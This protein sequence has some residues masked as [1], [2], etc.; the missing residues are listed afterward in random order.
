VLEQWRGQRNLAGRFDPQ[1]GLPAQFDDQ[2]VGGCGRGEFNLHEGGRGL[3]LGALVTPGAEGGVVEAVL[4]RE[5][6]G[7]KTAAVK[8]RQQSGA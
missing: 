3:E 5:G 8:G 7:G 1:P 6:G 4:A 2:S